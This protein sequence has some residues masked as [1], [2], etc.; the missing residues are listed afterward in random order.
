MPSD[1]LLPRRDRAR[2]RLATVAVF[3]FALAWFWATLTHGP[4]NDDFLTVYYF[5]REHAA[6]A[7][8]RVFGEFTRGWFGV[9]YLYRPL[10]SLSLGI[11]RALSPSLAFAHLTNVLWLGLTA[12]AVAATAARL[13]PRLPWL[14]ALGAG[15]AVVLHPAAVE[16]TAW[17]AARTTGMQVAFLAL[18]GNAYVRWV[19][20]GGRPTAWLT[21]AALALL[22]KE[23]AVMLP[24]LLAMLDLLAAPACPLRLRLR[25]LGPAFALL[26]AWALL[27]LGL[28]IDF[29]DGQ[30]HGLGERLGNLAHRATQLVAPIATDG[31]RLW[32]PALLLLTLPALLRW[33]ARTLLLPFAAALLLLPTSHM[34]ESGPLDG[35]LVFDGVP[36]IALLVGLAITTNAPRKLPP[37]APLGAAATMLAWACTSA[38]WLVRYEHEDREA[39]AITKALAAAAAAA[40]PAAPFACTALPLLPLFHA[41]LWGALGLVPVTRRDLPVIGL[42]EL[43]YPDDAA[44]TSFGDAAPVHALFAAGGTVATWANPVLRPM[45]APPGPAQPLVPGSVAG[46][47]APAAPWPGSGFAALHVQLPAPATNVRLRLLDDFPDGRAFGVLSAA[48]PTGELWFD[49]TH[50]LAPVLFANLGLPF[51]GFAIEV[52]GA[53]APASLTATL[54]AS[55]SQRALPAPQRGRAVAAAEL[56]TRL[57]PPPHDGPLLLYVLLPTGA[58][59]ATTTAAEAL[60]A[61]L[62]E[63]IAYATNLFAPL[64]IYWFWQTPRDWHGEP[65]RSELDWALVR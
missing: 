9:P 52:D 44:P 10:I 63:H 41:K 35:R 59:S 47:F 43:M 7:W 56:P 2:Q 57:Q 16:P 32:W 4:R 48:A 34:A 60:P 64:T 39:Q 37:L 62:Q 13:A 14:A 53:A 29:G 61:T 11:D 51:R 18:A 36:L 28:G 3:G 46:Q 54:H 50:A 65:W 30:P 1:G 24:V 8:Q 26:L 55:L 15:A 22:C 21:F 23:G 5:D 38:G 31:G 40:T 45:P 6:V 27:R 20:S 33:R 19:Q 42:P 17:I 25:R 12:V 49:T 58:R